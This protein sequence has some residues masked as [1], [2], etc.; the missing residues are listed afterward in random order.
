MTQ[1]EQYGASFFWD[2]D[3]NDDY[4]PAIRSKNSNIA[5]KAKSKSTNFSKT[6][7]KMQHAYQQN[8]S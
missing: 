6:V 3:Q 8:N 1:N 7:S 2:N 4:M 5:T